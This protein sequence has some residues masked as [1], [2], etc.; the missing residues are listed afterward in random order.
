MARMRRLGLAGLLLL[1][2]VAGA[3]ARMRRVAPLR[4]RMVVYVGEMVEGTRPD[5]TWTV[6]CKGK[7]YQL[8][9]LKLTVLGGGATDLDVNAAVAPY[10]VKFTVTG[11]KTAVQ[12]FTTAPARQQALL[13]GFLRLD[14]AGRYLMLDTVE[15]PYLPTPTPAR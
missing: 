5:F 8:Y 6:T 14:P 10:Q 7:R 15:V 4:V 3:D 2:S 13:T 11:E 1:L 9:V 12:R